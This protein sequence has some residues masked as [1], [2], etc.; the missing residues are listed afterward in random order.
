[1]CRETPVRGGQCG[2]WRTGPGELERGD[3]I[4]EICDQLEK[5]REE[6]F[7]YVA[8]IVLLSKPTHKRFRRYLC[9]VYMYLSTV[10]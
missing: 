9:T 7:D 1:M 3:R 10:K 6:M 8:F 5:R 2:P 4:R